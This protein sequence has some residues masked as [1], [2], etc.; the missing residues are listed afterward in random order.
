MG[1][2]AVSSL[3]SPFGQ[4]PTERHFWLVLDTEIIIYGATEPTATLTMDGQPVPLRP[5]GSFTLRMAL[6]EGTKRIPV[7]A[8]AQD[9]KDEITITPVVTKET[10]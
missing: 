3:S 1:S 8:R 10:Y 5:D 2:G 4:P 6:P 7:T 9:G